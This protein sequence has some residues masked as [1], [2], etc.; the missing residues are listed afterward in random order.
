VPTPAKTAVPLCRESFLGTTPLAN[1][2]APPL[3]ASRRS[4]V[5][6]FFLV[7]PLIKPAKI[8]RVPSASSLYS[9]VASLTRR[10]CLLFQ[11]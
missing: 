5:G 4:A 1:P 2:F 10:P 6:V 9:S 8:K 11:A 3:I 7:T